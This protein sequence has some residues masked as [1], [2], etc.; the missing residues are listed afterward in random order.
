MEDAD[1]KKSEQLE[2][3]NLERGQSPL[4]QPCEKS[5][6]AD[7]HLNYTITYGTLFDSSC[8]KHKQPSTSFTQP[9]ASPSLGAILIR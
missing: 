3:V 8:N 1:F 7:S 9:F 2:C 5:W 6:T 4:T